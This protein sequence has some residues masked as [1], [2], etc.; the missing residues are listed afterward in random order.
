MR[1]SGSAYVV[2]VFALLIGYFSYQAWFNPRR[3]IKRQL[4]E[5]A[6]VLSAPAGGGD[7]DRIAR[8][9]RLRN[10]FDPDVTVSLGTSRPAIT[11]RDALV[12]AVAAWHPAAGVWTVTFVDVQITM[13]S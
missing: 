7:I 13:D 10:Y 11:S 1:S 8:I 6:E 5:L 9:G 2:V 3:V 4:G 12:A